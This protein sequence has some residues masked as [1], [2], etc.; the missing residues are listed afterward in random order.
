MPQV[1]VSLANERWAVSNHRW[2][3]DGFACKYFH[4]HEKALQRVTSEK[5]GQQWIYSPDAAH[6]RR[7]EKQLVLLSANHC[8]LAACG[9][10]AQQAP[11]P[12]VVPG[13][14]LLGS[15][16]RWVQPS[17]DTVEVQ[18]FSPTA[19]APPC[20]V[21]SSHAAGSSFRSTYA[22]PGGTLRVSSC[23]QCRKRFGHKELRANSRANLF[24]CFF[25]FGPI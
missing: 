18:A 3:L 11:Q 16:E 5:Q 21:G 9:C 23:M 6:L 14:F 2:Y 8:C 7:Q 20:T 22:L 24:C 15:A 13:Y 1:S 12:A 17:L 10:T 4:P 19:H 25:L